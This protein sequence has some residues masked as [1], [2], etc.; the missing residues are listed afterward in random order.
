MAKRR[1]L[2]TVGGYLITAF[3]GSLVRV[4]L[5]SDSSLSMVMIGV[6]L[7]GVLLVL[8]VAR[9]ALKAKHSSLI[10]GIVI[11]GGL[12]FS[13]ACYYKNLQ[14]LTFYYPA[15][16]NG[17]RRY[18]A[19]TELTDQVKKELPS[20]AVNNNDELAKY[21][22]KIGGLEE[23]SKVW[24]P[25]SIQNA[26]NILTYNYIAL[27]ICL[28]SAVFYIINSSMGKALPERPNETVAHKVLDNNTWFYQS[29]SETVIVFVHGILS[30]SDACWRNNAAGTVW[31]E[32]LRCDPQFNDAAIFLGGYEAGLTS[33]EYDSRDAAWE[34]FRGLRTPSQPPSP[35]EKKHLFFICHSLGG[36]VVRQMLCSHHEAFAT[37]HVGLL[38][39]GSPSWGSWFANWV[40]PATKMI[41][42]DLGYHLRRDD[43]VLTDLDRDYQNLIDARRITRIDGLSLLESRG[44]LW[45][46]PIP[47]LVGAESASRYFPW[48]R[49]PKVTHGEL[50]K[51]N[52]ITHPSH[53]ALRDFICSKE[54]FSSQ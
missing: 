8:L 12:L 42:F 23:K 46:I 20:E 48:Y 7:F 19:G 37:K 5:P 54:F 14:R 33:G 31:P 40:A 43:R 9:N 4:G 44:R 32:L 13:I 35:L 50:V 26:N 29:S 17:R 10:C 45:G 47:I 18:V 24:T 3:V 49:I 36:I 6:A 1:T 51:P 38:L 27:W 34:L 41:G 2:F 15:D 22:A 25:E 21:L 52:T 30:N 28:S 11:I 53:C 39:C 16:G